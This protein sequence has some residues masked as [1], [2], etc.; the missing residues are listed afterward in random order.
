MGLAYAGRTR[1]TNPRR[2]S[3]FVIFVFTISQM[4]R[5]GAN[6]AGIFCHIFIVLGV[7][8]DRVV[9]TM[10]SSFSYNNDRFVCFSQNVRMRA[11]VMRLRFR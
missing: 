2:T 10:F 8:R 9:Q 6:G 3:S 1:V 4:G 11:L 7:T 5:F